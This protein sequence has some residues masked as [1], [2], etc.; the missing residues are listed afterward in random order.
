[1]WDKEGGAPSSGRREEGRGGR[2]S[3]LG[4]EGGD[5][6]GGA[7]SSERGGGEG[8]GGA[9]RRR[10]RLTLEQFRDTRPAA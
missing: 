8:R 4:A 9:C 7:P 5:K 3:Q 1:V 6:E 10:P 2:G